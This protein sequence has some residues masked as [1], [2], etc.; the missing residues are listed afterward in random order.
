MWHGSG[1]SI[2]AVSIDRHEHVV[3]F[4]ADT[5]TSELT[6][7]NGAGGIQEITVVGSNKGPTIL[8]Q[9]YAT[10]GDAAAYVLAT[11]W[12]PTMTLHEIVRYYGSV[13]AV[14][15]NSDI[16][17]VTLAVSDGRVGWNVTAAAPLGKFCSAETLA[18]FSDKATPPQP[19]ELKMLI[20]LAT[21]GTATI[22][23]CK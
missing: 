13:G 10:D 23:T 12:L 11:L 6:I 19:E 18:H 16:V 7:I 9:T 20:T 22:T 15:R 1:N 4:S 21:G 5:P 14:K 8:L 17:N 2:W 3:A